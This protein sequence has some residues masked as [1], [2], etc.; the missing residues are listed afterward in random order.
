MKKLFNTT[1]SL[2]LVAFYLIG[3]GY[4]SM[5]FPIAYRLDAFITALVATA[6]LAWIYGA[7]R[8][9]N[10]FETH[11]FALSIFVLP[12]S[13]YWNTESFSGGW[14]LFFAIIAFKTLGGFKKIFKLTNFVFRIRFTSV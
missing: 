14:V 2:L 5:Q 12:F 10:E 4:V 9:E 8:N 13:Y 1:Y 7:I 11:F 3:L 6:A